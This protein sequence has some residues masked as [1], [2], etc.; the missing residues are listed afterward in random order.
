MQDILSL[1]QNKQLSY[2]EMAHQI[3]LIVHRILIAANS[4]VT[5][6]S[7]AL[8]EMIKNH[9]DENLDK[10]LSLEN[11]STRFHYSKNHIINIFRDQYGCTPYDYYQSCR[12]QTA[13]DL[14]VGTSASVSSIALRLGY[15]SP[16]YFSKRF[17]KKYGVTPIEF[18]SGLINQP[19]PQKE[20]D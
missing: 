10:P 5:F 19:A 17:H 18:R 15:D 7:P 14:L 3:V 4:L 20:I 9:I 12:L 8:P 16:Q 1:I 13:R 2:E 11:L 6:D